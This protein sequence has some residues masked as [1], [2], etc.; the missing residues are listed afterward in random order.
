VKIG[1]RVFIFFLAVLLLTGVVGI[2][3]NLRLEDAWQRRI[4]ELRHL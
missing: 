4:A 3:L 2:A 1:P